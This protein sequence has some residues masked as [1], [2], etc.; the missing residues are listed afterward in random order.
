MHFSISRLLSRCSW[1]KAAVGLLILTTA[2]SACAQQSS[3]PTALSLEELLNVKVYSASK[4]EQSA[5]EAPSS[6]SVITAG[7]IRHYGYRTLLEALQSVTGFYVR[8]HNSYSTLG[9]RGFAPSGDSNGRILFLVNGHAINN[10]IDDSAP[11]ENDFPIDMDIVDRI[12]VVRG[13]SSSL[14]GADAFFGVVNVITRT[15]K[16]PGLVV[17]G[18]AGSLSTYKETATY[19]LERHG[20]QALFSASYWDTAAP[21]HLDAVEDPLGSRS[22]HDQSRRAFA[23]VSSHGFTLQAAA[24]SYENRTP[25]SPQWCGSCH[26]TDTHSTNFRGYADLQYEHPVWKGTQLTARTFY[27]TYEY[28]GQYNVIRQSQATCQ[29]ACHGQLFDY[30]TAHGDRVGAELKLTRRFL[31][32]H[33]ITIGTEY[34]DNLRQA[35]TNYILYNLPVTSRSF[36]NYARTSGLWGIYGEGEVRLHPKL[37]LNVGVRTDR[38]NYFVGSSTNPRAALIYTPRKST[39]LKLLYG[40]A[41]RAPSFSELYY[42]GMASVGAPNL[43]PETIRTMEGVWT[44]RF[45]NHVTLNASG[46]YNHIGSYIEQQTIVVRGIDQTTFFNSKATAKGAELEAVGKLTSGF[47][48]RLSYTYQDARNDLCGAP[49]PDSPKHLV[50]LN[51]AEPL[52]RR[53]VTP[54]IEA[55]YMSRSS[56]LWPSTSY[57]APPVLLNASLS[58]SQLWRGFSLSAS[59]YNLVGRSMSA[60]AIG[61]FEQ[62]YSVPSSSLLPEDRRSFRLE[63]TWSPGESSSKASSNTQETH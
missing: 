47:E 4:Y 34:R 2:V 32:K 51:L 10:N 12:E 42:A 1:L 40:T 9:V 33:R 56:T 25:Q 43:K 11:L 55:E 19:G 8:N 6:I 27:D 37:I 20:M 31:D 23:L 54:A 18:E 50:K 44:E 35:Q 48:G 22:N 52:F 36:V 60:P 41:F 28:H 5:A 15:G 59:A 30:D 3:D 46:F 7:D 21:G 38:Y 57:S 49:L 13:P 17:S 16:T 45:G 14:Y 39:T 29:S 26:Q 62:T 61:Y 24:S 53:T 63:L 58:T